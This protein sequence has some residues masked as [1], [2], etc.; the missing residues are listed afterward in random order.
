MGGGS[1]NYR[2][3]KTHVAGSDVF[4]ESRKD[5]G[6]IAQDYADE[7]MPLTMANTGR[8][9]GAQLIL[10]LLGNRAHGI[11]PKLKIF[12]TWARLI[13]CLPRMLTD[14]KRPEDI[15]KVDADENGDYGDDEVDSLRYGLMELEGVPDVVWKKP[16]FLHA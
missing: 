6:T 12:H 7:G 10:K 13:D 16:K 14:P 15:L 1:I 2:H 9:Q 11:P 4:A 5:G 3:I 8:L